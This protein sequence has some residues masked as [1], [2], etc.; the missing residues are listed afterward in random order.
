MSD[1]I[2]GIDF[3]TK[4]SYFLLMDDTDPQKDLVTIASDLYGEFDQDG[5]RIANSDKNGILTYCSKDADGKVIVGGRAATDSSKEIGDGLKTEL[6]E[7]CRSMDQTRIDEARQKVEDFIL[8]VL[9]YHYTNAACDY[10][11]VKKIIVGVPA[12]KAKSVV[13]EEETQR[14]ED[15]GNERYVEELENVLRKIINFK[16]S[17]MWFKAE[18]WF[19]PGTSFGAEYEPVLAAYAALHNLKT[20]NCVCVIDLGAG[21]SD[22]TILDYDTNKYEYR[23]V[24]H[25]GGV[26]PGGDDLDKDI[27]R[28]VVKELADQKLPDIDDEATLDED[29]NKYLKAIRKAKEYIYAANSDSLWY[30]GR[31]DNLNGQNNYDIA[32]V[33]QKAY[34]NYSTRGRATTIVYGN[35]TI[36]ILAESSI[37]D[38][39]KAYRK[40]HPEVNEKTDEELICEAA[41]IPLTNFTMNGK[42]TVWYDSNAQTAKSF[43]TFAR[44][45]RKMVKKYK[46]KIDAIIF[47]GGTSR[48]KSLRKYLL[49]Q[50]GVYTDLDRYKFNN[51]RIVDIVIPAEKAKLEVPVGGMVAYGAHY[52]FNHP[53][54]GSAT[55]YDGSTHKFEITYSIGC[56]DDSI[57]ELKTEAD[58]AQIRLQLFPNASGYHEYYKAMRDLESL[59]TTKKNGE[60]TTYPRLRFEVHIDQ[61]QTYPNVGRFWIPLYETHAVEDGKKQKKEVKYWWLD[62]QVCICLYL[63][64]ESAHSSPYLYVAV[65]YADEQKDGR[66]PIIKCKRYNVKF[67]AGDRDRDSQ[68][69]DNDRWDAQSITGGELK[70][71]WNELKELRKMEK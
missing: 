7:C 68:I 6:I 28:K 19:K 18:T 29:K 58:G 65:E 48:I 49:A 50:I 4:F 10:S 63:K 47:V 54:A 39:V 69:N 8:G 33:R 16:S 70:T 26:S 15:A 56:M 13:S 3:G 20:R 27:A 12:F 2:I 44:E 9:V 55:I 23:Y 41:P 42:N 17:E 31:E 59:F 14:E 66:C 38:G 11:K 67:A 51:E 32:A 24:D 71:L 43:D 37:E 1:K 45:L 53:N 40:A 22:A 57:L 60:E 34:G 5:F 25:I 52:A 64:S 62:E 46:S 30:I 21:T 61:T 36:G 35:D